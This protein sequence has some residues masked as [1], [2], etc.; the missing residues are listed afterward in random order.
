MKG[1]AMKQAYLATAFFLCTVLAFSVVTAQPAVKVSA[2]QAGNPFLS[3]QSRHTPATAAQRAAFEND[4][5]S[6][7]QLAA[8]AIAGRTPAASPSAA[9]QRS[10]VV[11]LSQANGGPVEVRWDET[12]TRPIFIR[13]TRLQQKSAPMLGKAG[14]AVREQHAISFLEENARLLRI[15]RP[16]DEFVRTESVTDEL[17]FTHFR[18]Q[19]TYQGF[20]VWGQDIRVHVGPD[21]NVESFNGRYIPT[22]RTVSAANVRTDEQA[23]ARA[24]HA[25]LGAG[26]RIGDSR[27]LISVDES[28]APSLCW[29]VEAQ[30]RLD[31]RWECFVDATTGKMLKIYNRVAQDGPVS[32]SGLDLSNQTKAL[33]LYQIGATYYMIDVSKPMYNAA[34]STFPQDAK[35]AIYTL[36]AK[37]TDSLMYFVTSNSATSWSVK[38]SVSAA[39]NGARVYDYYNTVHNRNGIDGS[40]GTMLLAVNFST[41]YNNAFWNGSMMVF[42]NGD[43]VNFSD[44]A[45]ALDVTA[46]EMTHGVVERTANLVYEN[47]SGALNE[48]FADVF[49]TLFEFWGDPVN[50]NWWIG[51]NVTTPGI[52]G[53]ALRR[54]DDPGAANIA[55]SGQ[56][57]A[58]MAQYQNLPNTAQGDHGGVHVNSGIPNKA[59]YLFA[60][61]SGMTKEDAGRVYFR[62]LTTYLTR[63]AQFVDCRLAVIKSAEDLF[64]GPGNAKALAAAAAFDAVG[65]TAG[66]P[67]PEPTP[68]PPVQ[69]TSYLA[70][71][72]TGTGQLYRTTT[73]GTNASPLTTI[74]LFSRPSVTDD[75]SVIL[76]VDNS[77]NV[78]SVHSDGT[79]DQTLSSGGGFNNVAISPDGRYLAATSTFQDPILY[80]FDLQN[81]AGNKVLPLYTPTYTQGVK[82]GNIVYPD[83]IDWTS[84]SKVVMYDA[85]NTVVNA[86]GSTL[87]YWDINLVRV[88][89]TAI[90]RLFPPQPEGV[91]I[92]DA[93]FSSNS[94]NVVAFDYFVQGDS[95]HVL[96]VNLNTGNVGQIT[97]NLFSLGSPSFSSDDKKVFYHYISG[98]AA[99]VW[100]VDVAADG[101]TGAGNDQALLNNAIFPVAFTVGSRPSGAETTPVAPAAF[102]L[103]PNYPN[104]FNPSTV[105]AYDLP[106]SAEVSLK[107]YDVLGRELRE[108]VGFRQDAG[109][110]QVNFDASGLASGIYLYRLTAGSHTANGKMLLTR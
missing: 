53:D 86:S 84:D 12:G 37:N 92:G 102:Q 110:H 83:R 68:Q 33:N 99:Q 70:V 49:G 80:V 108:L 30:R 45:G 87:G 82:T 28:G 105:I 50:A 1:L 73:A 23:A 52:A 48:S 10:A 67:T 60:T 71:I 55:F 31:E 39:Y 3:K 15:D 97:N 5:Q 6:I 20:E 95:V 85:F 9:Y 91:N 40:G 38:A 79:G 103:L 22:P 32:G 34:Q 88:A 81:A 2:A 93:V 24:V 47:Q 36:D 7:G 29:H 66:S 104:P 75:G 106:I 61:A 19:Q 100:V 13:G 18:Y 90:A 17:G 43:G 21:G 25:A 94:D 35:G 58:T 41:N 72:E 76:Y 56:Q 107:V 11:A 62:A 57:P 109:R 78:H 65:I 27:L 26:V 54:M 44:L 98:G 46:H 69:G 77:N 16:S 8:R 101:I 63:N 89:D 64:G 74:G 51:E 59:F 96:A 14:T 4:L 42:G